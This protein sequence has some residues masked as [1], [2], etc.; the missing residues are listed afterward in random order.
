[1]ADLPP[2]KSNPAE[3]LDEILT[4]LAAA[5]QPSD[6]D[7][8]A[9]RRAGDITILDM[10]G[11]AA[12]P[13]ALKPP[14]ALKSPAPDGPP[15][16][17][18]RLMGP[19]QVKPGYLD[20]L[21]KNLSE[22]FP[23]YEEKLKAFSSRK[24][25]D[26]ELCGHGI[27]SEADLLAAY[28]KA[29]GLPV[30]DEDELAELDPFPN[31]SYEFLGHW[32]C[33]PCAWDDKQ[34]QIAVSDPYSADR[35]VYIF[36]RVYG[37]DVSFS[38]AR[39]SFLERMVYNLYSPE[40]ADAKS[41][42]ELLLNEIG[43]HSE[44]AL[45]NMASEAKIVRLVNE[46]FSRAVELEA[47]DIH[48]EPEEK[49]LKIRF[50]IDG[51]LH[52]AMNPPLALYPAIASRIKLVGGLNI[53][54]RRLPQDGRTDI[55]IGRS[56][57][58]IR[59]STLPTMNGESIVMRLLRKDAVEFSLKTVGML[60]KM[61]DVFSHLISLPNGIILVVGPTGSGKSTTLY[62][63][64][65]QINQPDIKIITIE[66][67]VEYRTEGLTQIQVNTKIGLD[68]ANG[69]RS[70]V[71]QDPDVILVGEIR[72]RP[73]AEIAIHSALTGHLVFSTLHTNDAP[74][75][76]SRLLDMGVEGFLI[77]SSL[78]AVLSQRLVRKVCTDC[79]GAGK[80]ADTGAK[81]KRCGGSGFKGRIGIFELMVI[82][83]E[84]RA[85]INKG[86]DSGT[87][88]KAAMKNGMRPLM[89][90]GMEKARLGITTQEEVASVAINV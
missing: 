25:L 49:E 79:G 89:E 75:A 78:A 7:L 41:P 48:V 68:F 17:A 42:E 54:E 62:S 46:M 61:R 52:E 1:M 21:T 40:R 32:G 87:I 65:N 63:V 12:K 55:Q 69:L 64:M 36:H 34:A 5:P 18:A 66:D 71:R 3:S 29:S 6:G 58:D 11:L 70:I 45:R 37:R 73:T 15:D 4:A 28:A 88:A 67:P 30:V 13:A 56:V 60:E 59:I 22:L 72:D 83:D 44:E 51:K 23:Q 74:G 53:A 86:S 8:D 9:A 81:C 35:L 26:S 50:R 16:G 82:N 27:F 19:S 84:I 24:T 90:D 80:H 14:S 39:R 31:I 33:L 76:I 47:S 38:L 77:S 20:D 2:Q 43:E 85:L 10:S 57:L